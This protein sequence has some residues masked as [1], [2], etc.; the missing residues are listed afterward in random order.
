MLGGELG[1]NLAVASERLTVAQVLH[2]TSKI[3]RRSGAVVLVKED[4]TVSGIFSDGDLRRLLPDG[5]VAALARPVSA[6]MTRNPKR[7]PA[8]S[9][10]SEAM[11]L[12]G[13]GGGEAPPWANPRRPGGGREFWAGVS[14]Q[15]DQVRLRI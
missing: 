5:D 9:L 8:E 15:S 10:A 7:V 3:K 1:E 13:G 2:D 11:A 6:V 12:A 14:G 4:G